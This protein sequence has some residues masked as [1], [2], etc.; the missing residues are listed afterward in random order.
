MRI[1]NIAE[2]SI[3]KAVVERN[4]KSG[5]AVVVR[6]S[7]GEILASAVYP[8]FD[9]NNYGLSET[10]DR[11]NKVL[12]DPLEPGSTLKIFTVAA[13]LEEKLVT[14]ES[15]FFCENGVYQIEAYQPIRDTG[16]YG[17]L[18]VSEIVK[19]SSNIGASKI[20]ERL[21]PFKLYNYLSK[22]GFGQKTGLSYPAGESAGLLRP[23]G[24]WHIVD[25]AN[26]SFGQGL[27]VTAL[28]MVMAVSALAND[29]V[30]MR[31]SLVS[32]VIDA[33]GTII[34]HKPPQ[35]VRQ[36]VSPLTARQVM[37]MMRMAVMKGGTGR[38][39]DIEEY[40]VAGKTGTA[41][42]VDIGS[43]G[44]ASGK[45]VASFVG[46]APYN[47]PELCVLVILD[48]PYPA[49][50][51]G[52]VAAPV[53]KEIMSQSLPLLDI[54][55][56]EAPI[57]PNWPIVDRNEPGVPGV[58]MAE[59]TSFN[60]V[61]VSIPSGDKGH[62]KIKP[63]AEIV[64]SNEQLEFAKLGQDDKDITLRPPSDDGQLGVMPNL[65]GLS[66]REVLDILTPY[67]MVLEYHGTGLSASQEPPPGT[68][69]SKGQ[70]A[71]VAFEAPSR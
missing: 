3:A 54:P 49:Y 2:K 20:G 41:Q 21:G 30:L 62:G 29:G 63:L 34:E 10:S 51:G 57:E 25:A 67:H 69:V 5:M 12:T 47:N 53:F 68:L 6:P 28:Q 32:R 31:P 14:P 26:I 43:K 46:V 39:A 11:R 55:P 64:L 38:K 1:Q 13:A 37:A 7:T 36:V 16:V 23:P 71:R 27:S 59:Q 50:H 61:K 60:Y 17:D 65:R 18:T 35:I 70:M 52:E 58:L 22:F 19:K 42:K 40:P 8:T 44:Y 48:E 45:Y 33:N 66:M 15:V 56:T 9:P 24:K 4:A